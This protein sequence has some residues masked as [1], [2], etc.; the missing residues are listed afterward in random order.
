MLRPRKSLLCRGR[1]WLD[2]LGN[3][4]GLDGEPIW[5]RQILP[6]TSRSSLQSRKLRHPSLYYLSGHDHCFFEIHLGRRPIFL[7]MAMNT[8]EP[9]EKVKSAGVK[10]RIP[11][12]RNRPDIMSANRRPACVMLSTSSDICCKFDLL[13]S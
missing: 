9:S 7:P 13:V 2:Y 6:I 10:K 1:N 4:A 11:G 3:K 12:S 8:Y 5:Q